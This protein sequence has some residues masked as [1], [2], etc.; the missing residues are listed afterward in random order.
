MYMYMCIYI[1][2]YPSRNLSRATTVSASCNPQAVNLGV[3]LWE[4]AASK[5][6]LH[7]KQDSTPTFVL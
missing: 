4:P 7:R 2:I 1:Y 3:F 6:R 5:T